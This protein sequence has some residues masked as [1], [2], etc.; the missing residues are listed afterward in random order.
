MYEN[1]N[2]TNGYTSYQ[3]SQSAP[4]M[5]Q[6]Q[7]PEPVKVKKEKINFILM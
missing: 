7:Q 1:D 6:Y 5:P 3:P 2:Y 4:Q